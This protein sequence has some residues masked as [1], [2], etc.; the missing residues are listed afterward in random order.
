MEC[1]LPVG[2]CLPACP[3]PPPIRADSLLHLGREN[4]PVCL[5]LHFQLRN[6]TEEAKKSLKLLQKKEAKKSQRTPESLGAAPVFINSASN[7][8]QKIAVFGRAVSTRVH[9]Y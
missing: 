2:L 3:P 6:D 7:E 5:F 8:N 1:V 9:I 4:S